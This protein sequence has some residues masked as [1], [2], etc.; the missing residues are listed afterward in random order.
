MVPIDSTLTLYVNELTIFSITTSSLYDSL[1][2]I[3]SRLWT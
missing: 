1:L 3:S 2:N